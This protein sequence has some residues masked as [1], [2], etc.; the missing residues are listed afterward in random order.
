MIKTNKSYY[1]NNS[2]EEAQKTSKYVFT[3]ND[4]D[5]A[6]SDEP[7]GSIF[8]YR[9]KIDKNSKVFI[10]AIISISTSKKGFRKKIVRY[11]TMSKIICFL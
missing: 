8:C 9:Y 6:E 1:F 3:P 11:V 2:K 10:D 7:V 5:L 4:K